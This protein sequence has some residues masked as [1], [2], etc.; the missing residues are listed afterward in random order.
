MAAFLIVGGVIA[1]G[2]YRVARARELS[3]A[4]SVSQNL[5]EELTL[6][7]DEL[8]KA[9]QALA[10]DYD[11]TRILAESASPGEASPRILKAICDATDWDVGAL[12]YVDDQANALRCAEVWQQPEMAA[13]EFESLSRE[14]VFQPGVG[15]PGRVWQSGDP[16]WIT[17]LE[18]D[19][20]FPRLEA[21]SEIGLKSAFAFPILLGSE[22][23]GVGEFFSREIRQRDDEM[24]A[25]LAGIGS[26]IGQLISASR[27]ERC[28]KVK[29]AFALWR[30]RL[31]T[32]S[33]QS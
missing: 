9:H 30:K 23:I 16:S 25:M 27:R 7:G 24:L 12:W 32:R 3:A 14:T 4:L 2:R 19:S 31:P 22:V 15:L 18:Q 10:L 33:S 5:T 8:G 20:N 1:L 11:V 29:I 28:A 26:D 21:A 17:E 13:N 6:K